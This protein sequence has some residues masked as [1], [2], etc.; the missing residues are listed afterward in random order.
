MHIVKSLFEVGGKYSRR[1]ISHAAGL[2]DL[3]KGGPWLTGYVQQEGVFFVF[4]SVGTRGRTGHDYGNHFDGNELIWSGKTG[5]RKTQ[6]VIS[7]MT[8]SD[9]EVHIFWRQSD[10]DLFTYAG[11]GRAVSVSNDVPVLVRWRFRPVG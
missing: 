1:E 2:T 6:P 11:L 7:K 5:S 10:R 8:A 4:C 3:P 9:A